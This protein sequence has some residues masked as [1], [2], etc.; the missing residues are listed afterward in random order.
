MKKKS[1][2]FI[3]IILLSSNI[4]S[5]SPIIQQILNSAKQDSLVYFVRELSGNVPTIING[6]VQ[7]IIS[8]NKFQPGNSLAET[9]IKQK[10]QNYGML[11]TIQSFSTT[12]KNVLGVQTG[13]EFPNQKYII[14]AHYDDMPSGTTAPGADDNAS[15]TAAVIEAARIFSQ[16][17]F[18]FTIV[19]ALWDEEEQGLV[20][21]EYYATQAAN[22]G[23]SILGVVNMDMIAYD[24]NGD[25]N[26]D[27]HNSSVAN[28]S[29][30]KDKMLEV[31]LLYGINL[32]LDVVPA[33]PYSDHQSFLDHGYGAILLIEDDNDF[34]PY[35]HTTNDLIQYFNQPYFFK[36][37]KLCFA[38]LASFTLN[39]N[40]NI[41]HTP[42]ASTS[43]TTP[44]ITT[45]LISTGLDIGIGNLSPRLYYRTKIS[46]G[47]F[48]P[49]TDVT[50]IPT[51][52][53]NY[54]FTIPSLS[55]GTI[56]QYYLAAQDIN[57]SIVTTLPAGG[58]GFNPPGSTPPP[59]FF[60]FY[61]ASQNVA[62]YDEADNLNDWTSTSGWNI[63][64][65]K[66]VSPPTSF[67][68]S[69]GGSYSSNVTSSLKYNTQIDLTDVLG[70]TLEFDTQWDIENDWDYGQIQISTNNGSTWTALQGLFT[71]PGVGTFQPNGEPLYD[72]TQLSWVHETIDIS[73]YV[74][75]NIT[76]RFY[77]RTDGYVTA[78]GWYVDNIKITTYEGGGTLFQYSVNIYDGWNMVSIP[79][80]NS[81]DQ[82]INTWWFYRV[83]GSN[84]FKYAGG[85]QQITDA[86]PGLGYWMKQNGQR[87][88]NTGEEWPAGG[89]QI[90]AH[91]P[92]TGISGWNMIGGYELAAT[93]SLVTTNPPGLQSGPIYAY[94]GG[95][96]VATTLIPGYGYWIKLTGDGQII[97]PEF[98][99]KGS[100]SVEY[101]PE[102]W[103]RIII[104]DASGTNYTLYSVN[105]NVDLYQ[106]E[107]PPAPPAGM[108]DIRYSSGRIAEDLN[109]SVKTIEM[110]GVTYPLTV[111]V[112]GM[113]IRLMDASGKMIS[114][115]LK[116]GEDVV[117]SDATVQKLMVSTQLI[118]AEY[119]LEQN[120]PNPFNPSTVIEFSLPEDASNVTLSIYNALGE[121]VAELVNTSLTAGR[122]QYQ[123]NAQN[124]A[125][126]MY[127]YELRTAKFVSIK[128]MLILK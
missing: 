115:N 74:N 117:I 108:F 10:L 42:V 76:I 18:P 5:Q 29:A 111:R 12:G 122:Y 23:D 13:N 14:C 7:T 88:Y 19:Y 78:D 26:A 61:V 47:T 69:P 51:E 97:L 45:A 80:L 90:V 63:T 113:D 101:F 30:L 83:A 75:Q 96:Q 82:S 56:V 38:T 128:K 66:Y 6:T 87:I 127:I 52:S 28:T 49:F 104:S 103:G 85:Y 86:T 17:D 89:I 8:R 65:A 67:T 107:L 93:A 73:N 25:G 110:Q 55:L 37:A 95:Y 22:A 114:T 27:V 39:L 125:S 4:F 116:S 41:I 72:G 36:M 35:Y 64:S 50:G 44:I 60:Q 91:A 54:S 102:N 58:S 11:T 124:V 119:A 68:D 92:L 81:P 15:G 59:T 53:G 112:I 33:Q 94:S 109:S 120:Y 99:A 100:G 2:L 24:G 46:G 71:N 20:G 3:S 118:P 9:Y 48:G 70:A 1:L 40:M 16:Y 21:S 123:W 121:K 106:Y 105:G 43:Q 34:H 79:G 31:N 32:D 57:S 126:G 84:V 77:F 98:L 62:L